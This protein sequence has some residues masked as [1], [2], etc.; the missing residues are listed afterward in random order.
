MVDAGEQTKAGQ[1][2]IDPSPPYRAKDAHDIGDAHS[3]KVDMGQGPQPLRRPEQGPAATSGAIV[4]ISAVLALL[5]GGAGA[6]AYERFLAQPHGEKPKEAA[7][8]AQGQ[9]SEAQKDLARLDDRINSLSEEYKQLQSRLE[10]I[11][12]PAPAP[13]LA[14]LE[15]KVSQ[16]DR[17]SRQV[18]EIGKKLDPLSE[19]LAKTEHRIT[20]LDSKLVEVRHEV[21]AA[22]DST[23][24]GRGRDTAV[25]RTSRPSSSGDKEAE[26]AAASSG[27]DKDESVETALESGV[28]RFREG[29][30]REAYEVFRKLIQS[31]PDDARVWYYAALSYGLAT[32]DWGKMTETM[33][34]EGVAREKAGKPPKP[35]IDS[36]FAGL[37]KQTG[38]EWLDFYRRRAG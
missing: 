32:G 3:V 5:C 2:P 29:K 35:E 30:Y 17:L 19:Q 13:D 16:V 25:S 4:V 34:Q 38:K 8:T 26:G 10:S 37:T 1:A 14:P 12:K 28:S 18:E 20:E 27:S 23:A 21:S 22:P 9:D 11:P 15:M 33:V 36:A 24:V 31:N 7:A 6:W